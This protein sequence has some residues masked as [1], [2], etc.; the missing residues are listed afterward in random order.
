[1]LFKKEQTDC[2]DGTHV[3]HAK[4]QLQPV[5]WSERECCPSLFANVAAPCSVKSVEQQEHSRAQVKPFFIKPYVRFLLVDVPTSELV[6]E[7]LTS[8]LL[9]VWLR[10]IQNLLTRGLGD[11]ASKVLERALRSLPQRKHI[12]VS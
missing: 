6:S 3:L 9:Q 7:A 10:N 1:M 4:P 8:A 5:T 11:A 12:K 2:H